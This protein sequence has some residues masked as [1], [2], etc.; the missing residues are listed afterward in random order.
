MCVCVCVRKRER[1]Y[2][3]VAYPV[4]A[5]KHQ[6][7][8][9]TRP[10]RMIIN[11]DDNAAS[12]GVR[13]RITKN[14]PSPTKPR[15]FSRFELGAQLW[16]LGVCFAV[17]LKEGFL[18]VCETVEVDLAKWKQARPTRLEVSRIGQ[19][20]IELDTAERNKIPMTSGTTI[21]S[22]LPN[23]GQ[24]W[25]QS[26]ALN[27]GSSWRAASVGSQSRLSSLDLFRNWK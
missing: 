4:C 12:A 10:C 18:G 15:T 16:E 23:L 3:N 13:I 24:Q 17:R 25:K 11:K 27:L 1:R 5:C 7:Y 6:P 8:C 14:I 9:P 2:D 26:S 19:N 21:A 22:I 20:Q